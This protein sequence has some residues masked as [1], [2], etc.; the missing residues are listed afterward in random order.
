MIETEEE[1]EL[2]TINYV[3]DIMLIVADMLRVTFSL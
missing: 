2:Q 1:I 3:T